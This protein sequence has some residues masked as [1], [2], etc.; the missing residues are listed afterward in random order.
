MMKAKIILILILLGFYLTANFIVGSV[1]FFWYSLIS[2]VVIFYFSSLAF[3]MYLESQKGENQQKLKKYPYLTALVPNYNDGPTVKR[4]IESI[5]NQQYPGHLEILVIDDGSTDGSQ[6]IL[7]KISGIKLILKPQ[8]EGKAVALNDGFK[9]AK[10]EYIATIDAD[11]HMEPGVLA[12]MVE[13]MKTDPSIAAAVGKIL[14]DNPRNLLQKLIDIEY[15]L[16]YVFFFKAFSYF[17]GV[18]VTPG[19]ACMYKKNVVRKLGGFDPGNI[20]EDMEMTLRMQKFGYKIKHCEGPI[21]FTEAPPT[22]AGFYRQRLRWYRGFFM[23]FMKYRGLIFNRKYGAFGT[24][25]IPLLLTTN[26]LGI[27]MLFSLLTIYIQ[28]I[29]S[30]FSVLFSLFQIGQAS[31]YTPSLIISP[32]LMFVFALISLVI[33]MIAVSFRSIKRYNFVLKLPIVLIYALFYFFLICSINAVSLAK[34]IQ[35]SKYEW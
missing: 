9:L 23:N 18:W 5:K 32:A 8:N 33:T 26:I 14:I 11:T 28:A 7:K 31:L 24:I 13:K 3:F 27:C 12:G 20:T 10:G 30:N 15:I 1:G 21:T 29:T 22:L 6:A 34:E 25:F 16:F 4:T 35:R 19:L 17:D 2:M